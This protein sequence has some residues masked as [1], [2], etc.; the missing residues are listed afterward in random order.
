[1]KYT[2]NVKNVYYLNEEKELCN[3]YVG[4]TA[5][6]TKTRAEEIMNNNGITYKIILK[7]ISETLEVTIPHD[8]I[9]DGVVK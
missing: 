1:M 7:I 9:K 8:I 5:R 3:Y 2:V 4:Q 6:L